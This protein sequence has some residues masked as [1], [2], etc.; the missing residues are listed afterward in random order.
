MTINHP[1]DMEM[2]LFKLYDHYRWIEKRPTHFQ[3]LLQG[4]EYL[5]QYFVKRTHL[6]LE[7]TD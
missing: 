6:F 5:S 4:Y 1:D 3:K 2:V 7:R